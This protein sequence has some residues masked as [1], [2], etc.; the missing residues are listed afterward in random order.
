V[1][2]LRKVFIVTVEKASLAERLRT[3]VR[4]AA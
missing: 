1:R 2:Y 4:G 3:V